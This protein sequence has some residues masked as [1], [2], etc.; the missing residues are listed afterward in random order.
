M[1]E[2]NE[3]GYAKSEKHY[4]GK[5]D[6]GLVNIFAPEAHQDRILKDKIHTVS[7]FD[8]DIYSEYHSMN[9]SMY[10]I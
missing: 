3:Y 5:F 8:V 4:T 6:L 1:T 7:V 9:Y 2:Y 10:P